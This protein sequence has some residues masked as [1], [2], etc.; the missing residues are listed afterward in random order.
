MTCIVGLEHDGRVTIGGDSAAVE[1]DDLT[2]ADTAKVFHLGPYLIG[3]CE[4]F[5]AGQLVRYRLRVPEPKT[6]DP[7]EHL[8]TVFVDE[9]RKTLHKGGVAKATADEEQMPGALMVGYAGQLFTIEG[10]YAV[11]RSGYGYAALGCGAPYA[12]GSL[13][14]SPRNA[15][16]NRR[17]S[18]ALCA[19][20]NH[21]TAVVSPFTILTN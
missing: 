20:E 4:S 7:V 6:D 1:G 12:L 16:P 9:L 2:A 8:A 17:I 3:Y 19:A 10:D 13:S 18:D 21:C 14:S 5:R 15:D 11:I